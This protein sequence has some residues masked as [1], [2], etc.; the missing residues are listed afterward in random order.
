MA[1]S[2]LCALAP[3]MLTLIIARGLQG[4]GG[5]GL[6][7][8]AQTIVGDVISPRDRGKY[9][10]YFS[11]VWASSAILGPTIGGGL[12]EWLGWPALFWGYIPL[13]CL[14]LVVARRAL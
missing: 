9:A 2:V 4:L 8:L 1:S 12:A 6:I 14:A 7:P 3:N 5:G 10:A 13:G 11:I